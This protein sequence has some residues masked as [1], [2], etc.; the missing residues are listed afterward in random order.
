MDRTIKCIWGARGDN[1]DGPL[2]GGSNGY[3]CP[4]TQFAGNSD[5]QRFNSVNYIFIKL[6]RKKN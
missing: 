1:D 5:M 4:S 3:T 6:K 2:F